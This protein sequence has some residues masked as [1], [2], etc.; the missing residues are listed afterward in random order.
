MAVPGFSVSDLIQ[1]L[2]KAKEVYDAFFNE[3]TN[4]AAQV[5][6]LA[7]DIDLFRMNLQKHKDNV[8]RAG[9]EYS[10]YAAVSRTIDSCYRFLEE[11]KDVLDKKRRKSVVGAFKT[12]KFTFEQDEVN[13]LRGQIAAH[14][15]DMMHYSLNVVL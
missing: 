10:G 12:A 3:Y 4:T 2:A 9:L 1:A 7:D 13:R 14:K 5:R 11:Y 6:D 15:T 8:E